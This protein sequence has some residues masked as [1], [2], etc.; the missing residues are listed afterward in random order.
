MSGEK[1]TAKHTKKTVK[2]DV[3]RPGEA[4]PP[5]TSK[6]IIVTNRPILQDPMVAGGSTDNE[7][8]GQESLAHVSG[9]KL[10]PISKKP[11]EN[12][13][14]PEPE[15]QSEPDPEPD[16]AP[17]AEPAAIEPN[18][19][20]PTSAKGPA[21]EDQAPAP[22]ANTEPQKKDDQQ[23]SEKAAHDAAVQKLAESRRY[24][25]PINAVEKR[26]ARHFVILGVLLAVILA[27]AW[28]DIALDAGLIHIDGVK[29]VTHFF[30]N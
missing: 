11:A 25:L 3:Q 12:P 22:N 21:S 1:K 10:Q 4:A 13:E 27:L 24:E 9:P 20:T 6:P 23:A 8:V 26:K 5:A 18:T 19:E 16:N 14:E 30:S 2:P 7:D 28:A 29:P 17:P 15:E